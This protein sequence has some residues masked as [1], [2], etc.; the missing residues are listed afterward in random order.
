MVMFDA[1]GD[2][3]PFAAVSPQKVRVPEAAVPMELTGVPA[4]SPRPLVP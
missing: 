1:G 3:V 4:I 2:A